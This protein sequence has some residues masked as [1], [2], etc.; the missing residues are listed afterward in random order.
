MTAA[1]PVLVA[2]LALAPGAP[3]KGAAAKPAPPA[4]FVAVVDPGHGGEQEVPPVVRAAGLDEGEPERLERQDECDREDD[5]Q[6]AQAVDVARVLWPPLVLHLIH[7]APPWRALTL[8]QLARPWWDRSGY[9]GRGLP[10][11]LSGPSVTGASGR[12]QV[13]AAFGRA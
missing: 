9:P 2:L 11:H 6:P 8:R 5:P 1:L 3:K 10:A 12:A 13:P 7:P 4:T